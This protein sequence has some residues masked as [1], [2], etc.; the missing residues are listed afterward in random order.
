MEG[1]IY[2]T[3][4]Q[5][6]ND[7]LEYVLSDETVDRYGDVIAVDGWDLGEFKNNPIALFNHN[8]SAIVGEWENVRVEKGRLLGRLR[9]AAEGTS[10]L[11]DEIRRLVQQRILRAVSVGFYPMEAEPLDAKADPD[12][13]PFRYLKSKLVECSLVAVPANPNA[14]QVG[15]SFELPADIREQLRGK[16]A[17]A[18]LPA[19]AAS[20]GKLARREPDKTGNT[21]MSKLAKRIEDAQKRINAMKDQLVELSNIDEPDDEQTALMAELPDQIADLEAGLERDQ[22]IEQA[23]AVRTVEQQPET[24]QASLPDKRPYA[25]PA[26]KTQPRDLLI[27]GAVV[28][29]LAHIH[30]QSP[31]TILRAIYPHD[32]A[33]QIM[34]RAAV[35]PAKTDVPTWAQELV[36]QAIGDYLDLLPR[37]AIYPALS[38][39]GTRF[40]FG[41]NGSIKIPAR[42]ATPNVSG[43]WVGEGEPIPVRRLGFTSVTLTPKKLGVISTFTRE[44]AA[45]STPAIEGVIREA[46]A[47]DTAATVDATLIDANPATTIRPAGLLN[48]VAALPASA[49]ADA[50]AM[51]ADLKALVTAITS[52]RGGRNIA[53]L[54]NPSQAISIAFQQTTTG[55]F[56]FGSTDEAGRRL[57]VRF[58]V[59]PTVPLD[60]VIAVDAADFSSATGDMP[61]YDV[62]DQATIH[63]EDT[64][65][66]PIGTPGTPATVAAPVR[67]LWQTASIGVRMLLDMNWAMRRSGMVAWIENVTW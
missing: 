55:E 18:P 4:R 64:T 62:S 59:S 51:I 35:N 9:L 21:T 60:T 1:L 8:Q 44:L 12:W 36:Q 41:R 46:M 15:K 30:K 50:L 65:P 20:P 37:D 38:G 14:L 53:I 49:E 23:I 42:A 16:I 19:P 40:T 26:K 57:G 27:R 22:R 11:V 5:S 34:V 31:D 13:G 58:I 66:L 6:E 54:I 48:G 29:F 39:M 63:E 28:Q 24:K 43:A 32:E 7:P 56:M 2:R 33:V 45:H 25:V 17:R 47:E 61:E 52:N 10:R 3:A 67:S